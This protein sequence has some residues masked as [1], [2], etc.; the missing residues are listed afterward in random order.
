VRYDHFVY[1]PAHE[2]L[3]GAWGGV[4][5]SAFI[6]LHPFVR[7][8]AELSW[9][10]TR[11]YPADDEIAARGERVAWMEIVEQ[12]ELGNCSRLAAALLTTIGAIAPELADAKA[13][14]AL[15]DY[16][17]ANPVW[18]PTEGRF[19]PLLQKAFLSAFEQA[20][21]TQLIHVP[22]FPGVDP[23]RALSLGSLR[24]GREAFPAGGSLVAPDGNFLFTVDWESFFTLFYGPRAFVEDVARSNRLE[25][26]FATPTTEHLWFNYVLGCATVTVTPEV[27]PAGAVESASRP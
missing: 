19:E 23:V 27:W 2:A 12:T 25:G 18:M 4:Y 16:L 15:K 13:R 10:R 8:P 11:R 26:F 17:V 1:P 7:V 14:D 5:E 24:K 3:L 6:V 20:G 21:H 22:E 9:Q